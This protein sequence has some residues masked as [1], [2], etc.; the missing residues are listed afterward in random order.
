MNTAAKSELMEALSELAARYPSWR[1][2]QLICNVAGWA[3][4]EVWDIEDQQLLSAMR[5][6]LSQPCADPAAQRIG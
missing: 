2:G 1:L 6:H 4:A 3:D 5:Q